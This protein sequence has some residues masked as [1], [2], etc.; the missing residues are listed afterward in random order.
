M[1]QEWRRPRKCGECSQCLVWIEN[2]RFG[3]GVAHESEICAQDFREISPDDPACPL[4]EER[5]DL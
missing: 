1:K 4:F 3:I 5:N 2:V